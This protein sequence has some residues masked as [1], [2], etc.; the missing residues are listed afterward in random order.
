MKI[1]VEIQRFIQWWLILLLGTIAGF[2]FYS[3]FKDY[4]RLKAAGNREG[5]FGLLFPV[6]IMILVVVLFFVMKLKT[7]IDEKG[8]T[9]QFIPFHLKERLVTWDEL[10]DC[11]V[12]KYSPIME[13]GGWGIRG[14]S[15]KGG[16]G[17]ALNTRGNMGIQLIYKNG[18][19][20]LIG[21][22]QPQKAEETL[23][24]YQVKINKNLQ[25]Q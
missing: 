17:M 4:S 25:Q 16:K 20:L 6:I 14:L 22:Q 12:R 3:F 24:N 7:R 21:T 11:Y 15:K 13:Y 9:Y 10:N 5:M 19:K 18:G 8:I 2:T 1:F 23:R